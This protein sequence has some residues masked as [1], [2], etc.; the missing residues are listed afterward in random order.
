MTMRIL[1]L[2]AVAGL[3]IGV[4]SEALRAESTTTQQGVLSITVTGVEGLVQVRD[5]ADKPWQKA[6]VGM[7]VTEGAEFRTGPKSAVRVL[8]PPDQTITLDRLGVCKLMQAIQ[9]GS[10]VKTKVGMPYGRTRYDIEEAGIEHQSQLVTPS[11][12]LAIRGTKVSV[13]DQPP[14][15]PSAVSL[16]GRALYTANKRQVA[17][18]N[19]GQGKTDVS[20]VTDSPGQYALLQTYVDPNSKFGRPEEDQH[21]INQLQ[22]K[23]DIVL[24]NGQLALAQGPAVTDKQLSDIISGQGRFNISLR[25]FGPGD[26]DLF[27]LTPDP[28]TLQPA[29]TLGNPSYKGS[30]FKDIG[31][32]GDSSL[33]AVTA[34]KTPDGGQIKFDQVAFGGGG[35]ELA[36][37]NTPVPQ[38]GYT[39]AIVYYDQRGKIQN[40]PLRQNFRVDAFLDGKSVPV[41]TNFDEI[42]AGTATELKF[43][44]TYTGTASL[45][46]SEKILPVDQTQVKGDIRLS[47]AD[48]S[49]EAVGPINGQTTTTTATARTITNTAAAKR[50]VA[51]RRKNAVVRATPTAQSMKP[52][53]V[54]TPKI[55]KSK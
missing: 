49:I 13:Y 7:N 45:V 22:S 11:S 19:K 32:F 12:T 46:D 38:V 21:L 30:V 6:T 24:R 40:Y 17:F 14:F 55:T 47:A 27:V 25:W 4:L 10:T 48:L 9:Q 39:I 51:G 50:P 20:A 23:G 35:L 41:L 33:P 15:A 3:A 34:A 29:Y 42:A 1:R 2:V 16:T 28:K 31:L 8:I 5:S 36:S 54:V 43:G 37:W 44:P 53:L 52:Q 18:G 26:F